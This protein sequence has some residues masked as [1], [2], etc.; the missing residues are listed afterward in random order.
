MPILKDVQ[1]IFK[2]QTVWEKTER[3]YPNRGGVALSII[4]VDHISLMKSF[5]MGYSREIGKGERIVG[6]LRRS[7][8]EEFG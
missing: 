6:W 8:E 1:E 5:P 7:E 3:Y 2:G 4:G